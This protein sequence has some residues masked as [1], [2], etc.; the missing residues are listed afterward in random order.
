M[1]LS[2]LSGEG[3]RNFAD[4]QG[5]WSGCIGNEVVDRLPDRA[6]SAIT[7]SKHRSYSALSSFPRLRGSK[8][9]MASLGGEGSICS[10]LGKTLSR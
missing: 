6:K 10:R 3:R 8:P 7:P 5:C 2:S 1:G 9:I 4:V